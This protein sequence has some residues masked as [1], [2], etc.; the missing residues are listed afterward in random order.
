[1]LTQALDMKRIATYHRFNH[2]IHSIDRR[3]I[4]LTSD[5]NFHHETHHHMLWR[6]S[7]FYRKENRYCLDIVRDFI[8]NIFGKTAT[9]PQMER[10]MPLIESAIVQNDT[11][12]LHRLRHQGD[13]NWSLELA[14]MY[15]RMDMMRDQFRIL[16]AREI[17]EGF[18]SFIKS[19]VPNVVVTDFYID[20]IS[21]DMANDALA[22]AVR[23]KNGLVVSRLIDRVRARYTAAD[24]LAESKRNRDYDMIDLLVAKGYKYPY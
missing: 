10:V 1:M 22:V 3:L 4:P 15:N 11:G 19:G 18:H 5:P 14:S 9:I 16:N 6:Y 21:Q 12:A 8:T 2:S 7:G 23:N 13:V 20:H 17:A 24:L